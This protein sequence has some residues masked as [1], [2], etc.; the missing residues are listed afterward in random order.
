M[1]GVKPG[2]PRQRLAAILANLQEVA[3]GI[4]LP[5]DPLEPATQELLVAELR[6][7]PPLPAIFVQEPQ[8]RLEKG[9]I[10]QQIA[11]GWFHVINI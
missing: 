4:A 1:Q 3:A 5:Q 10:D 8:R 7:V 6:R 2:A 11:E 9:V